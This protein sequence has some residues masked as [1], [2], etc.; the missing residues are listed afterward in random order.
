MS[1]SGLTPE[2]ATRVLV[3]GYFA[4]K[5]RQRRAIAQ[6]VVWVPVVLWVIVSAACLALWGIS[7]ITVILSAWFGLSAVVML[8]VRWRYVHT[9]VARYGYEWAFFCLRGESYM[10]WDKPHGGYRYVYPN[11]GHE[12]RVRSKFR[13]EYGAGL[14]LPG[15]E[16]IDDPA[17]YALRDL[18]KEI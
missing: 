18:D 11:G 2:E 8:I 7:P 6:R 13:R 16:P 1:V 10:G 9:D 4:H 15:C 5:L 12:A 3:A 17:W 14:G